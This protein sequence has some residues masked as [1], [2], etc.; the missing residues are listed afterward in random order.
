MKFSYTHHMPYTE[1]DRTDQDWPV[2]N[3]QFDPQKGAEIFR[4]GIDN[5]VYAE[6][7]GFDWIGCNEHHMSPYGLMPNPNLVGACVAE[8]TKQTKILQSGVIVPL[9]NPIRLAEEYAMLDMI[10]GGR[11][12]AGFMRGIPHEYIAYNVAPSESYGRMNEAIQLIKKAWS[13]PE[14]FGWEG[15]F[16]QYRA[17]S[18]WP[19]P[20][21]QP[22]PPLLMSASSEQSARLAAEHRATMGVL[23]INNYEA[24]HHSIGVYKKH[25]R[26]GGWEPRPENIMLAMNCCIA[27]TKEEAMETLTRGY[28]YF[29]NVLGGGI[30]TA[31]RLVVQKT[32]YYE[33]EKDAERQT[34]KLSGHKR[35]SLE[36]RMERGLVMCGTPDMAI[37]Q[38]TRLHAEFGHGLTN[39]SIKIGNVPDEKV[40]QTM[41]FLRDE[42]FPAVR[43]LGGEKAAGEAA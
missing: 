20:L 5:K 25:A 19:R 30:R 34:E 9:V 4:Q 2:A 3:K 12:V 7:C 41:R 31:Q 26:K 32:R 11:L 35:L 43:H 38:I 10:S 6:E 40:D 18:I 23:R 33:D 36:E 15:E 42:V 28:D 37:E 24:A 29:F 1:V 39:L 17:V 8:R 16:Y 21:Q 14:P 13:E 22:H 27:P